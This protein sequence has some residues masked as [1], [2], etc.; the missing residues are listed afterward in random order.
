MEICSKVTSGKLTLPSPPS[1]W[2]EDQI[3]IWQFE[4]VPFSRSTMYRAGELPL[5]HRDPFD[6]LLIAHALE[7][8]ATIVTPDEEFKKYAVSVVW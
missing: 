7:R 5:H 1:V 6:R 3:D 2:I 8:R 4:P